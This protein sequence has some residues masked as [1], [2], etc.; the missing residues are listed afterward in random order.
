MPAAASVYEMQYL[1]KLPA[2]RLE[3]LKRERV[4]VDSGSLIYVGTPQER[5]IYVR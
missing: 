5:E 2:G 1:R 3:S 4:K